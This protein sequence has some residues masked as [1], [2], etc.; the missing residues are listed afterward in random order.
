MARWLVGMSSACHRTGPE[1]RHRYKT[2]CVGL[3]PP[4][5]DLDAEGDSG[6]VLS[7]LAT[8]RSPWGNRPGISLARR[9][10]EGE[11]VGTSELLP[12][13]A[14]GH[15]ERSLPQMETSVTLPG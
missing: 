6:G 1:D 15:R 5:A 2:G 11:P 9:V 4:G 13:P 3:L 14:F 7:T 10:G 12:R 8:L